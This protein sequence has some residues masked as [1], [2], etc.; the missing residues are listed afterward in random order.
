VPNR[1]Y[2]TLVFQLNLYNYP[3]KTNFQVVQTF[4]ST[5]HSFI[6]R[7]KSQ[8]MK[9]GVRKVIFFVQFNNNES[10]TI[11][12]N[13]ECFYNFYCKTTMKIW[14]CSV[15]TTFSV[16]R[17]DSIIS[18]IQDYL[19]QLKV[20][21]IEIITSEITNVIWKVHLKGNHWK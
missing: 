2:F 7:F 10:W 20:L 12:I 11:E 16:K 13:T 17:R 18:S 6:S 9:S 14:L 8:E 5:L 21:C 1:F 15:E 19:C 3:E 4:N